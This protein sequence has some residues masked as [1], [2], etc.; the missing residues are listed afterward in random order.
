VRH[1]NELAYADFLEKDLPNHELIGELVREKLI[2]YPTVTREDFKNKG[3]ITTL[4]ETGKLFSDIGLPPLDAHTDRIM[5]CGSP[6]ML[7]D[8]RPLFETR[9]FTEGS[10]A[11]P[12]HYVIEKAFAEQ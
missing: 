3:R 6:A 12:G 11:Q 2:Y 7:T 4:I 10:V 8:L 5:L 9:G 1:A